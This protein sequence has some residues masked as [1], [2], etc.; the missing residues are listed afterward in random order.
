MNYIARIRDKEFK[1]KLDDRGDQVVATINGQSIPIQLR[2]I[3]GSHVYSALVGNRS[4]EIEIRRNDAGYKVFHKGRSFEFVVEDERTAQLKKS[5]RQAVSHKIEQELKAP[6]P[7][8]VVAI[9]VKPG[10]QIKKGDGLLI[11][12]A[13]KMENEIRAPFDC[14]VKEIKV[15]EKQAVEKGQ[16]LVVFGA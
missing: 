13:M 10:Q 9:E 16:V 1:L 5:M 14:V 2:E 4:F 15:Q 3:D 8:L 11:I 6:M 7:G 12:E